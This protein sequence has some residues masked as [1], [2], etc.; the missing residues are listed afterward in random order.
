MKSC[1]L[2]LLLLAAP[3]WAGEEAGPPVDPAV[4]A[5]EHQRLADEMEQLARRQLWPGVE[6]KYQECV[7]LGV[8]LSFDELRNGAL[9]ARGL[10]NMQAA[11]DR[12]REAAR[13]R[14]DKEIVDWLW[15]IDSL[16]GHVDLQ[17]TPPRSAELTVESLPFAPDQRAAV[18]YAVAYMREHGVFKG[19]LPR[20]RYTLNGRTF[21]VDPGVAFQLSVPARGRRLVEKPATP[22]VTPPAPA[23]PEDLAPAPSD[24]PLD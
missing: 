19:L 6:L 7:A 2:V 18:D 16:Y 9:A 11:Y 17:T 8:E 13:V 14:A 15:S 22:A 5:A 4:L 3:V 10:G 24:G 12:L 21:E 1:W 20:G 23:P